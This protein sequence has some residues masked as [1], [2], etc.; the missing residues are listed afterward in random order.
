MSPLAAAESLSVTALKSVGSVTRLVDGAR[1][2]LNLGSAL[3]A[4]TELQTSSDA[5]AQLGWAGVPTLDLG[6][7]SSLL[8]HSGDS[9][10]LRLRLLQGALHVD[11]RSTAA[12]AVRDVR[13]NI[14]DLRL[15][16]TNAHAWAQQTEGGG[17][18]CLISGRISVQFPTRADDLDIPGQCLRRSGLETHWVMVPTEVL[19]ERVAL[20]QIGEPAVAIK[21]TVQSPP[22]SAAPAPV[23]IV[24]PAPAVLPS[25]PAVTGP[26]PGAEPPGA[27][28][29]VI[30]LAAPSPPAVVTDVA[31]ASAR[32]APVEPMPAAVPE[33]PANIAELKGPEPADAPPILGPV[34]PASAPEVD[35]VL[36]TLEAADSA[37]ASNDEADAVQPMAE[38]DERRW[39]VVFASMSEQAAAAQEATRLRALGLKAE[40]REYRVGSRHGFRVGV[41][42]FGSREEAD[43]AMNGLLDVHPQLSAWL[44]RY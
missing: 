18:I 15:R 20:T 19:T 41:G 16:V 35:V 33:T 22:T 4:G 43:A 7:D 42:R 31:P 27:N 12:H 8:L 44:A 10:V 38:G 2:P 29:P 21:P 3:N 11:T 28:V 37:S 26:V 5:R 30:V 39:S 14:A 6:S 17:Q 36:A 25:P 23:T 34:E 24:A 40:A 9:T 32:M 13:L 1:S